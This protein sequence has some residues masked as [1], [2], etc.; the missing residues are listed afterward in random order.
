M[1]GRGRAG[2]HSGRGEAGIVGAGSMNAHVRQMISDV[3]GDGALVC[4]IVK[5]NAR[6][7][8]TSSALF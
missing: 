8:R 6:V 2:G 3:G 7:F 4:A 1:G 5:L